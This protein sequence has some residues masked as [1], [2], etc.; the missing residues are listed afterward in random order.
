MNGDARAVG[1]AAGETR[2]CGFVPGVQT[3]LTGG[4]ADVGFRKPEFGQRALNGGFFGGDQ[5]RTVIAEVVDVGAVQELREVKLVG[6]AACH[7]V[8]FALAVVATV[9]V[10]ADVTF[11]LHLLGFD[12]VM[13]N[14]DLLRDASRIF[15]FG[16]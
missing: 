5:P 16:R 3:K 8:E 10:I 15:P 14:P 4:L 11:A 1:D 2:R 9:G 7:V 6:D 13:T 12:E